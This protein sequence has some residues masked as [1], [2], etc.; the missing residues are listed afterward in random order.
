M[1]PTIEAGDSPIGV[2][3]D[4]GDAWRSPWVSTSDG[5]HYASEFGYTIT[6]VMSERQLGMD[7]RYNLSSNVDH[8]PVLW[9]AHPLFRAETRTKL[10]L[11]EYRGLVLD[12]WADRWIAWTD[13]ITSIGD[14][15]EGGS[16]KYVLPHDALVESAEIAHP[17]GDVVRISWKS[18]EVPYLALYLERRAHSLEPAIAIEP[19]T[20]WYDALSRA[21]AHDRVQYVNPGAPKQWTLRLD[22][23]HS[24]GD[25]N[26]Q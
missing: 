8:L 14:L 12:K 1:L 15:P 9:A 24:A 18:S 17:N 2:L 7:L 13:A 10:R 5:L 11:P 23:S 20:G 21:A 19:M 6:R 16:V 3:P 22:F 25:S 26:V 4:H